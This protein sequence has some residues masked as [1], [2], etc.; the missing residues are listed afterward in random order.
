MVISS[1]SLQAIVRLQREPMTESVQHFLAVAGQPVTLTLRSEPA[2]PWLESLAAAA[3]WLRVVQATTPPGKPPEVEV[4][5]SSPH[6]SLRFVGTLE[7]RLL[8]ALVVLLRS[9]ATGEV[10]FDTPATPQLLASLQFDRSVEV[11]VGASCPFCPSVLAAAL[12]LGAYSER[13]AVTVLRADEVA[14]A[15]IRSVPTLRI[16]GQVAHV[17]PIVEYE[18]A[19]LLET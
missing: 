15:E 17:G 10:A 19:C 16:D 3:S 13:I 4:Q 8:E 2:P 12:R 7:G 9:L 6:G 14:G 1:A 5:G 18:L 11:F